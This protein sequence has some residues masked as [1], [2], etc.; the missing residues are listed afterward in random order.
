MK[1]SFCTTC[2]DRV[3]HL[4]QTLPQNLIDNPNQDGLEVEFVVLNYNSSDDM[5]EWMTTDPQIVSEIESGRIVYARTSDPKNFHMS[6]AKNMAH[7]L[8]TGDVVCNLDADN[9]TGP[10]FSGALNEIFSKDMDMIVKPHEKS[11]QTMSDYSPGIGGRIAL[12][13]KTFFALGGYNERRK[14]WGGEDTGLIRRARM[15][16]VNYYQFEDYRFM[17]VIGHSD[18]ARTKNS[19]LNVKEKRVES[20][21]IQRS[22][23]AKDTNKLVDFFVQVARRVPAVLKINLVANKGVD[24]GVGTVTQFGDC[25]SYDSFSIEAVKHKPSKIFNSL[26][27]V[28][29]LVRHRLLPQTIRLTDQGARPS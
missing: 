1:I 6:H 10:N 24:I 12:P 5:H 26:S 7:R 18:E 16:N 21:R 11:A 13:R 23:K 17:K 14:G 8:A 22:Y 20:R 15:A 2:M 27:G 25:K 19:G 9:Y 4:K 29:R 3:E 28:A